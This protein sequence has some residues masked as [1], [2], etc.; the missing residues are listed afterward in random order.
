[1][2]EKEKEAEVEEATTQSQVEET[3]TPK[4][5][6]QEDLD[7][8]VAEKD[9]A[10]QGLQKV[11]A[12]KDQELE[13]RKTQPKVQ[14]NAQALKL[15]TEEL[16]SQTDEYGEG[17]SSS[18]RIAQIRTQIRLL[19]QQEA[20]QRYQD[21]LEGKRQEMRKKAEDV[22]LDP[23]GEEFYP[24]VDAFHIGNLHEA[25]RRISRILKRHETKKEKTVGKATSKTETEIRAEERAKVI[26]EL[27]LKK[28]D[29]GGP[30]G[31][32]KSFAELEK[33]YAEGGI[34]YEEYSA[35][36]KKQNL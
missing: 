9:K 32:S 17:K 6:T 11:I 34:R 31:T 16:A 20:R 27:G 7:A 19:E 35:A 13:T 24:V 28:Q 30:S 36:R 1:M 3:E 10:Y 4:T 33:R 18:P 23:D 14:G 2:A 8:I 5:V 22:G 25:E 21:Q 15:L 12:R 26:D 29:G